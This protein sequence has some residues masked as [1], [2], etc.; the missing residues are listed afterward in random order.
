MQ[1][2]SEWRCNLNIKKCVQQ[3]DSVK[4]ITDVVLMA[5]ITLADSICIDKQMVLFKTR[6]PY[7]F[8]NVYSARF[9][10]L[11]NLFCS[12]LLCSLI[13]ARGLKIYRDCL[14]G[15]AK[16]YWPSWQSWRCHR[17]LICLFMY[18]DSASTADSLIGNMMATRL[19]TTIIHF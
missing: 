1:P 13:K 5:H 2:S 16:T 18:T 6:G 17:L 9:N 4:Q 12:T 15:R 10:C 3:K 14:S 19:S 8:I 11:S 7:F